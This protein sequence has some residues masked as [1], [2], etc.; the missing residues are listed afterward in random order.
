MAIRVLVVDDEPAVLRLLKAMLDPQQYDVTTAPGGRQALE[1]CLAPDA[2]FDALVT[3]VTMPE[4]D[5]R[6]LVASLAERKIEIPVLFM[7]G[8]DYVDDSQDGITS[9]FTGHGY[10]KLRKPFSKRALIDAVEALFQ[11][12]HSTAQN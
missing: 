3:D 6:E 11:A 12:K 8:Y 7:T 9:E 4:M 5:G 2:Q 1:L 10:A